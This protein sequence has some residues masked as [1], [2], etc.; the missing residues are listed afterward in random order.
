MKRILLQK[1]V[2]SADAYTVCQSVC[3]AV[4]SLRISKRKGLEPDQPQPGRLVV[5]QFDR[6]ADCPQS[7]AAE[8]AGNAA[9]WDNSRSAG[10]KLTHYRQA[11][12][13]ARQFRPPAPEFGFNTGREKCRKSPRSFQFAKH[14]FRRFRFF[15]GQLQGQCL[16]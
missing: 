14:L 2:K 16:L 8:L 15:S 1:N 4:E 3:L 9:S 6:S 11:F 7:A 5:A 10:F 12:Q 13:P